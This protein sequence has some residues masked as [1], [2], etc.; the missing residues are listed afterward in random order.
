MDT[1]GGNNAAMKLY[2][3]TSQ[4]NFFTIW[5]SGTHIGFGTVPSGGLGQ[6]IADYDTATTTL[7]FMSNVAGVI[8]TF[9]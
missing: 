3:A 4:S 5:K 8:A 9:G 7:T 2:D 1:W 6:Q